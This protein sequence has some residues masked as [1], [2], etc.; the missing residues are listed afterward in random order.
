MP[1][2]KHKHTEKTKTS[3]R[4]RLLLKQYIRNLQQ[5]NVLSSVENQVLLNVLVEKSGLI[6][7]AG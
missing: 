3:N 5:H 7:C 2:N 6:K 4:I 1:A